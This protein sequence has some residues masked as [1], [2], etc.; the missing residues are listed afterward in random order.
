MGLNKIE[1]AV[2]SRHISGPV[3]YLSL[4]KDKDHYTGVVSLRHAVKQWRICAVDL[5]V[6]N[7]PEDQQALVMRRFGEE[8]IAEGWSAYTLNR[9]FVVWRRKGERFMP[10]CGQM[11]AALIESKT[12]Q[13]PTYFKDLYDYLKRFRAR[14]KTAA[15]DADGIQETRDFVARLQVSKKR[16]FSVKGDGSHRLWLHVDDMVL[17][18]QLAKL[19]R[20]E[21]KG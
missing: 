15:Q 4:M 6:T 11:R 17:E 8:C 7:R 16:G 14:E 9:G 1:S 13:G 3:A 12:K 10:T 18:G 19:E 20:M 21:K 2:K 5:G